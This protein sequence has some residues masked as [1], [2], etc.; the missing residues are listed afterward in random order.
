THGSTAN[1]GSQNIT[2]PR[3]RANSVEILRASD[4]SSG[5][6]R[7]DATSVP[8]G[9][10]ACL[11]T[12]RRDGWS[13]RLGDGAAE[14]IGFQDPDDSRRIVTLRANRDE[15]VRAWVM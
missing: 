2:V 15:V 11:L 6:Y 9:S 12:I 1:S 4:Y 5:L 13:D 10:N 7:A 3:V 14:E 8:S